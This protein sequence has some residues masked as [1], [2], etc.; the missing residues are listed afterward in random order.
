MAKNAF[1]RCVS[2]KL[3]G[4]GGSQNQVQNRLGAAAKACKGKRK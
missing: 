3:R 4:K 1:Q 2:E